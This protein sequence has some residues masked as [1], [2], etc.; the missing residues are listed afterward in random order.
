MKG[1]QTLR[2]RYG[3]PCHRVQVRPLRQSLRRS[4]MWTP[5]RRIFAMKGPRSLATVAAIFSR[6]LRNASAA[7]AVVSLPTRTKSCVPHSISTLERERRIADAGIPTDGDPPAPA[8]LPYPF[9]IGSVRPEVIVVSFK[10]HT[11]S[12]EKRWKLSAQIS[13]SEKY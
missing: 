1:H 3:A 8:N 10:S 7:S 5:S 4:Q 11:G 12:T 9:L 13:I 6:H 2:F